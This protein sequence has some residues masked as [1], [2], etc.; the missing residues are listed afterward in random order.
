MQD[1]LSTPIFFA[2]KLRETPRLT[3]IEFLNRNLHRICL[4]T[5][6][7]L[8]RPKYMLSAL[9]HPTQPSTKIDFFT[10]VEV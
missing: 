6:V 8:Q 10:G 1:E 2:Y 4:F 3:S 5:H 9:S 7:D